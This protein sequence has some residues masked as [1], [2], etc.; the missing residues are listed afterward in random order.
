M[1]RLKGTVPWIVMLHR[2]G[3]Q[4]IVVGLLQAATPLAFWW[5]DSA[6][7]YALGLAVIAAIY[8]GF[9]V[10]CLVMR[11]QRDRLADSTYQRYERIVD[12][13]RRCLNSYG[14]QSL[15]GDEAERW[16]ETFE[17]GEHDAFTLLCGPER[18]LDGYGEFLGYFMIRKVAA[19]K[20]DLRAAGTVTKKLARWLADHGY[21][22]TEE[23]K[24]AVD[25]AAEAGRE[26][27]RADELNEHLFDLAM[28]THLP[29]PP[30][31]IADED[32][33]EDYR[34]ISR[35]EAGQLWFGDVGPIAVPKAASDL[36]R[37]GWDVN[38][39]LARTDGE[40]RLVE[41]GMVYP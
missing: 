34:P 35:V 32:W 40:W 39:V 31:E 8:V 28:R 21:V 30:T 6:T 27:P 11:D 13:L 16:R 18:I 3:V 9:A 17:A 2:I 1:M 38:V 26:L 4:G 41:V 25:R 10:A 33:V 15:E 7:V 20:Q 19:T 5:L 24:I 22:D 36:A 29:L 12:L 23:A 37:I 14:Y